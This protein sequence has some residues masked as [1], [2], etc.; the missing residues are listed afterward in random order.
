MRLL[1]AEDDLRR[2]VRDRYENDKHQRCRP[3]HVDLMFVR[4][5]GKIVD[6]DRERGGGVL[7]GLSPELAE[8]GGED[9]GRGFAGSAGDG[10]H[11]AG[12]DRPQRSQQLHRLRRNRR[13]WL[14]GR[15]DRPRVLRAGGRA[16]LHGSTKR[17][18]NSQV[19][20]LDLAQSGL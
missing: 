4:E 2:H 17:C 6:Q 20:R 18:R 12:H 5:G 14:G 19:R 15:H 10:E 3:C 1:F 7:Q 11:H 16:V 13:G 8:E 9:Q